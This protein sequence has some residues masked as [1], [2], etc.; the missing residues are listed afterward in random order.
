MKCKIIIDPSKEEE[1]VV[2]AHKPSVITERIETFVENLSSELVG[3]SDTSIHP[4]RP[5]EVYCFMLEEGKLYA[6]TGE[7]RFRLK[8]RLYQ[9]ESAV[10]DDF[11]KINQSCIIQVSKIEKFTA[12]RGGALMVILKNGYQ[13]YVARRQLKFVKERLGIRR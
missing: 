11:I 3:Y 1:V 5:E 13:D 7:N 4:L 12:S 10:G 2:Y 8:E 6:V 9:I